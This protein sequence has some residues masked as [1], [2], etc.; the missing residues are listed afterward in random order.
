MGD[1]NRKS[2]GPN[3]TNGPNEFDNPGVNPSWGQKQ[4]GKTK[5][6]K[7]CFEESLSTDLE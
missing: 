4:K 6:G 1:E 3:S 7:K 5:M 2:S